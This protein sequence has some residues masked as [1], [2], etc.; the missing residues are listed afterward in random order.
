MNY[1]VSQYKRH[2]DMG[3]EI[4]LSWRSLNLE[5]DNKL[6]QHD[7]FRSLFAKIRMLTHISLKLQQIHNYEMLIPGST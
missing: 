2:F 1:S 5:I 7:M 3:P 6:N 4:A